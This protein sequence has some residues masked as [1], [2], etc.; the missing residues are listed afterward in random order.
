MD[1]L[2]FDHFHVMPIFND[3]TI[4]QL[5]NINTLFF[6]FFFFNEPPNVNSNISFSV[7]GTFIASKME[8][9]KKKKN[10]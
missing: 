5:E 10:V 4:S 1:F 8:I 3:C 2:D 9:V 6:S 7:H